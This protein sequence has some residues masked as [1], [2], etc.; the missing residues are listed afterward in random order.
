M[1]WLAPLALALASCSS[2]SELGGEFECTPGTMEVVGCSTTVGRDCSGRPTMSLCDGT[3][4][5]E[6]CTPTTASPPLI[7][8]SPPPQCPNRIVP[9]PASGS[10]AVG[11]S[12]GG[13]GPYTCTWD[14]Q[15]V[16]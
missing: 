14:H 8:V 7:V 15:L 3:L 4:S 5:H 10:I 1:R 9:C 13:S 16:P 12:N 2:G 6:D 11:I